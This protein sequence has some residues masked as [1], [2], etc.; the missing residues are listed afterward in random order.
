M[1][2][3]ARPSL[4]EKIGVSIAFFCAGT[5][6]SQ[7]I[8]DMI[9]NLDIPL[10]EVDT[11]RFRGKGWPGMLT[12]SRKNDPGPPKSV[13]YDESWGFLQKYRP[14]RCHLCPDGTGEFADIA[15]GDPWY[16]ENSEEEPGSSLVLVRTEKGRRILQGALDAGF[17]ILRQVEPGVLPASQKSL[18]AKRSWIWGRLLAFRFFRAPIPTFNGFSLFSNWIALSMK[19]K[20][21]STL[22]TARRIIQRGYY[23]KRV[24]YKSVDNLS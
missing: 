16:R 23:K 15:C 8:I 5:P 7:G 24:L 18:L 13:S 9:R 12:V 20:L 4:S 11:I 22:G 17:V 1:S 10:E 14:Y 21:R 6:A 19:E 2:E 3:I